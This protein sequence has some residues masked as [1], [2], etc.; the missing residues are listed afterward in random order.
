MLG[1]NTS[2]KS[3]PT[4]H[5]V[6]PTNFPPFPIRRWGGQTNRYGC[7][8]PARSC[9]ECLTDFISQDVLSEVRKLRCKER[10][11]MVPGQRIQEVGAAREPASL[12]LAGCPKCHAP[13][14]HTVS[15]MSR[16]QET[17]VPAPALPG[18]GH[19]RRSG[20]VF[21]SEEGELKVP[22]GSM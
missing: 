5:F 22:K 20:G 2:L 10:K 9:V 8:P 6:L 14:L 21:P 3:G 12:P 16:R 18:T 17:Q 1:G 13:W 11:Q 19:D 4:K 7:P 15:P